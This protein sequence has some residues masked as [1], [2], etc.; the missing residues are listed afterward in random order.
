MVNKTWVLDDLPPG[1]NALG[2]K[3]IFEKNLE[4]MIQQKTRLLAQQKTRLVAQSFKKEEGFV[5]S[6]QEI[7]VCKLVKLLYGIKQARMQ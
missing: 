5:V 3:W 1:S 7:K 6:G 2:C 4:L